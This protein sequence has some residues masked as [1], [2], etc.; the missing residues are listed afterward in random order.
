MSS[1]LDASAA[2]IVAMFDILLLV[3]D[4]LADPVEQI[5]RLSRHCGNLSCSN[6]QVVVFAVGVMQFVPWAIF[7]ALRAYV[8]A[9]S[10]ILGLLVLALSLAPVGVNLVQYGY[11]LSGQNIPPFGCVETSSET[12]AIQLMF[13]SLHP[14][15]SSC[16]KIV[17]SDSASSLKDTAVVIVSRAGLIVADVLLI[18]ITWAKLSSQ[19][20]LRKIR[21]S[22]RLSLSDILF[23]NGTVY[24]V[25]L[26]MLNATHLVLSISASVAAGNDQ[27]SHA[28]TVFSI[29]LSVIAASISS[30]TAVLVSRFLLELQEADHTIVRLD[31]SDPLHFS[32][33]PYD[34][35]PSFILSLGGVISSDCPERSHVVHSER[36]H[37]VSRSDGVE[38]GEAQA[39]QAAELSSYA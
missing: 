2:A 14:I 7:S 26:F 25:V 1:D 34:D 35:T 33:D 4:P 12:V 17:A 3:R 23:R 28:A 37:V 19:E 8:L 31:P 24:F 5:F 18:Y 22:K 15:F 27:E 29:P 6:F 11:R 36:S 9:Q 16:C 39:S 10:K 20:A 32:R 30:I 13:G 38:E 21:Q